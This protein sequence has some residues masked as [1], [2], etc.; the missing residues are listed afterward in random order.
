MNYQKLLI[1]K[2]K[3]MRQSLVSMAAIIGVSMHDLQRFELGMLVPAPAEHKMI[4]WIEG[5]I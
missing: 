1:T 4:A 2:R 3:A 5:V